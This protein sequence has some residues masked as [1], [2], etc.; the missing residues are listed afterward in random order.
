MPYKNVTYKPYNRVLYSR[1]DATV[2]FIF[3]RMVADRVD[4]AG[5]VGMWSDCPIFFQWCQPFNLKVL[6]AWALR[7]QPHGTWDYKD[8][9]AANIGRG[10]RYWT[11]IPGD[12]APERLSYDV[13]TNIHYGYVGRAHKIPADILHAGAEQFGGSRSVTDWVSNEIGIQL[14][15]QHR[16]A[17]TQQQLARAVL[18]R[19]RT[20]R[21][22][23]AFNFFAVHRGLES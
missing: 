1:Y 13:W 16:D 3:Q 2:A 17:L 10:T 8:D 19:M 23:P 9:L 7:V 11:P 22:D 4:G 5:G 21:N 14:W 6:A 20:F 18:S 12:P 15:N